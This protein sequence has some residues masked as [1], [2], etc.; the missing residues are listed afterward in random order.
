[1]WL[2][3]FTQSDLGSNSSIH[4]GEKPF[5]CSLCTHCEML[6]HMMK[7]SH[8][9]NAHT[10][11]EVLTHMENA[12]CDL[13]SN[14]PIHTSEKL[15]SCLVWAHCEMLRHMMK[16]SHTGKC[17]DTLQSFSC[18]VWW[19]YSGCWTCKGSPAVAEGVRDIPESDRNKRFSC[20]Q[21]IPQS[22]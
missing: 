3:M 14:S 12:H 16:G 2:H 15:F 1:M 17:S 13:W 7:C 19:C 21:T 20:Q 22:D 11:C 5:S 8:R 4:T 9:V 6:R 10:Y 18:R